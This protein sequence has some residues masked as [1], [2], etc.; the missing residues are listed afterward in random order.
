MNLSKKTKALIPSILIASSAVASDEAAQHE[1]VVVTAN[2]VATTADETIASVTVISQEEIQRSQARS[3]PELLQSRS[4][5]YFGSNGGRGALSSAF[6]RGTNSDHVVVLVDGV[7]I[8]SATSGS[9][10]WQSLPLS[11]IERVEFVK[12]PRASL[13]GSE[14]LGGVVQVFTKTGTDK[15]SK[16]VSVSAGNLGTVLGSADYSNSVGKLRYSLGL[17]AETTQGYDSCDAEAGTA[18]AGCFTDEPDNDG[19]D[20]KAA[21]VNLAYR[22]GAETELSFTGL[23][24][25]DELEFDGGFQN[26]SESR[27]SV[28]GLGLNHSLMSNWFM[29]LKLNHSEDRS[30][31]FKDGVY[32]GSF[33]TK[34]HL[35]SLINEFSLNDS[36]RLLLAVDFQKDHVDSSTNYAET[37]REN[38]G[39]VAQYMDKHGAHGYEIS[40]R[41]D[42]NEQFGAAKTGSIGYGYAISE[43]LSAM[44]SFGT[45]FSAPKFNDLYY[46]GSGNPD[47][48]PEESRSFEAGLRWSDE[49]L[50]WS[51]SAYKTVIDDLITYVYNPATMSGTNVNLNKAKIRGI[52]LDVTSQLTTAFGAALAVSLLKAEDASGGANDGNSLVRRP[53]SSARLSFFYDVNAWKHTAEFQVAGSAYDN[54]ANTRVIEAHRLLNLMTDYQLTESLSIA[55]KVEN[56]FDSSIETASYYAQPPRSFLLTLR[57]QD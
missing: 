14:A 39:Y 52:D 53:A 38:F 47:L 26:E 42:D 12:G 28:Y 43:N 40:A 44:A 9:I 30:D 50:S 13:Y 54:P 19:Y 31:N 8:G 10:S 51:A 6:V 7:K 23:E 2:R 20:N 29:D 3:L 24:S 22:L 41:Y 48:R 18:F 57:Y 1:T 25:A 27:T 16:S 46:P 49:S 11:Q 55:A 17:S 36:A 15:A 45:A 37:E 35:A 4:G 21:H 34:R 5:V 32:T 56:V 33:D